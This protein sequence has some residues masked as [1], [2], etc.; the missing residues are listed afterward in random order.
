MQMHFNEIATHAFLATGPKKNISNTVNRT[1][2]EDRKSIER[3]EQEANQREEKNN[4]AR[5]GRKE[6]LEQVSKEAAQLPADP[7][8]RA[9]KGKAKSVAYFNEIMEDNPPPP[10]PT[11][12]ARSRSGSSSFTA[13]ALNK[14]SSSSSSSFSSSPPR[15]LSNKDEFCHNI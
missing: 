11:W 7:K 14:P 6:R 5:N 1:A 9:A 12:V 8:E 13:S 15:L 4:I 10:P 2:E 3:K